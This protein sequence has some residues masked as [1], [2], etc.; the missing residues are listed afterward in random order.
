MKRYINEGREKNSPPPP[1]SR[2][3]Q[4]AVCNCPHTTLRV[5]SQTDVCSWR[6]GMVIPPL[7]LNPGATS[8]SS[9]SHDGG[10]LA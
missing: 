3:Q 10:R 4:A 1:P 7:L 8:G 5:H 2:G 9:K 6:S